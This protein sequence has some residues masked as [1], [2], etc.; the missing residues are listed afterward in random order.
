MNDLNAEDTPCERTPG[1]VGLGKPARTRLQPLARRLQILE[2]AVR[3]AEASRSFDFTMRELAQET[4]VSRNLVYHYFENHDGLINALVA[5][6]AAKLERRLRAVRCTSPEATCEALVRTYLTFLAER[7]A[8]LPV[9]EASAA[10]RL[11]LEPVVDRHHLLLADRLTPLL[12]AEGR[13]L[14]LVRLTVLR[15]VEFMRCFAVSVSGEL[16]RNFGPAL[17][18]SLNVLRRSAAAAGKFPADAER[19]PETALA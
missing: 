9:I 14:A 3:T 6:E 10:M 7:S 4:G 12:T 16:P 19:P 13:S 8:V 17:E 1:P 15:S 11:R 18:L 2:A 5:H